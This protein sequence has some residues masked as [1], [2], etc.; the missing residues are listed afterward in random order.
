MVNEELH[1]LVVCG[2]QLRGLFRIISLATAIGGLAIAQGD[3]SAATVPAGFTETAISGP[4]GDAVGIT[5]ES[6]GRMYVWERTGKLW[7]EDTTDTSP[8]LLLNISEEVGAWGDHGMLG[9]ALDPNFRVNGYIY[10]L[11][12]VDRYY[13]DHFGAQNYDPNANQYNYTTIGRITR[14]TVRSSDGFRSVDLNSRLILLGETKTTGI[15]MVSDTHGVGSLVFGE[16]GTLLVSCGDGASANAADQGGNIVGS[17]A[18]QAR[19]DGIIRPKED[20]GA[21]R[22]QLVDC[23]NGKIL[24]LDPATGNGLSSNPYYD[25]ANPRSARSRVWALGMRNPCRMSLRP[26]TGSHF[27]DDGNPGV[28][29]IG[30]VGWN[31][32]EDVRVVTGPRQNFGWPVFEGLDVF[33]GDFYTGQVANLDAPN[34][35]YPA[36]GCT[37]Y[38]MFS[39]LIKEDTLAASGQPPFAN[40]CNASQRIPTSIPQ[41]LHTR[42]VLDWNHSNNTTRTPTYGAGGQAT[43]ANV[44]ANGS[45]VSGTQ[46]SEERRV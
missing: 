2:N 1:R 44:G 23:L 18:V 14:Y 17:Y 7:F 35:L 16:D 27:P 10:L 39:D 12:V 11:Y 24:R 13:L 15:P 20:V 5:F 28:L 41:F 40:P 46:R 36:S 38:F 37:Q 21:L 8:T 45:P 4:W 42:P 6:N 26:N 34:P 3:L 31:T 19:A 30:N 29:Y 25:S 22:A 33:G 32:W 43:V 9:F